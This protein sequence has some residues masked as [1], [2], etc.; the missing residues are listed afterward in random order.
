MVTLPIGEDHYLSVKGGP[1]WVAAQEAERSLKQG[2][3]E[4]GHL[5]ASRDYQDQRIK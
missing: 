1:L 3:G 4:I 2:G 5:I